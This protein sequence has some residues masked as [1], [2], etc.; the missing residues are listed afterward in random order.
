MRGDGAQRRRRAS[1]A[2]RGAARRSP[3]S[4][5]HASSQVQFLRRGF[6]VAA[7]ARPRRRASSRRPRSRARAT[8]SH[9]VPWCRL[10]AF[11]PGPGEACAAAARPCPST[12]ARRFRIEGGGPSAQRHGLAGGRGAARRPPP[13][14]AHSPLAA[15]ARPPSCRRVGRFP[16]RGLAPPLR[17]RACGGPHEPRARALG[18]SPRRWVGLPPRPRDLP[19]AS[20]RGVGRALPLRLRRRALHARA[21]V[22]P[23]AIGAVRSA[24]PLRAST[25]ARQRRRRA[26]TA[27]AAP[28]RAGRARAPP[29]PRVAGRLVSRGLVGS[30]DC[31]S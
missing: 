2:S 7:A 9:M 15:T 31:P 14:R 10:G 5:A 29:P 4:R 17:R 18:V 16:A 27:P 20:R 3:H 1:V 6:P 8:P 22:A 23:A 19:P 13:S 30:W 12:R 25:P 21:R 11:P 24:T 28:A 26:A